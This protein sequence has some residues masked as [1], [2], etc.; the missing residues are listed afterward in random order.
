MNSGFLIGVMTILTV[1]GSAFFKNPSN[2]VISGAWR[3]DSSDV[4]SVMIVEDGYCTMTTYN[5]RDKKFIDTKGGFCKVDNNEIK[6]K[7][8]FHSS[9]TAQV[10]STLVH[11]FAMSG[12]TLRIGDDKNGQSWS[13]I[14]QSSTPVTGCWR[15][16]RRVVD[17]KMSELKLNPRKTIKILSGTR[18]Q[19]MAINTKTKEFLGSGG[20]IYTLKNGKYTEHIE[21]FSRDNSR[22]GASLSFDAK[23]ENQIWYHSGLSSRGDPISETWIRRATE[24]D[25][26]R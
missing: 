18:F 1:F 23:V 11:K 12:K 14:D 24:L 17:G 22:V 10:G 6:V 26:N 19:W 5:L 13:T 16:D 9:D 2:S 4:V 20:G 3:F 15:I 25:A 7:L 8:E 21:F